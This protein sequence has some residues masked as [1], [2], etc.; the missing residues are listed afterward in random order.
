MKRL[1]GEFVSIIFELHTLGT[2]PWLI[3]LIA[4]GLLAAALVGPALWILGT[5][6]GP[7]WRGDGMLLLLGALVMVPCGVASHRALIWATRDR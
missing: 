7:A 2:L 6:L 3:W 4:T 5:T 1:W